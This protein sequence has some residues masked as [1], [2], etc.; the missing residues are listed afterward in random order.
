M[1]KL[2]LVSILFVLAFK[3]TSQVP[4]SMNGGEPVIVYA[5]P[6]TELCIQ[7]EIE[8]TSQQPGMFYRYAGRY[9]ATN[10]IITEEKTSY[11][12]KSIRVLPRA[13]PDPARTFSYSG[14]GNLSSVHISLS[15]NGILCGVNVPVETPGET[16]KATV[17]PVKEN[18]KP[19]ALLPLGEEYMMAGSEAKLAEGA[20]K[21]IYRIRESRLSLLT[22]DIDKLPSDG[23]SFK[24]MLDGMNTLESKLTE[25]F[26][27]KT[28][29]ESQTQT[30]YLT[31][32]SAVANDVLF[33][34]SAIKGLVTVDDLSGVPYYISIKP[35]ES[36]MNNGEKK[37]NI[38]KNSI[39]YILP[40]STLITIGDGVN[41]LLS[42]QFF[43]PQFGITIPLPGDVLKRSGVRIHIDSQSG[44]LLRVE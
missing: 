8:R 35:A 36:K 18:T 31:P 19:E 2:F 3:A 6:Q 9:L 34:L 13:I 1:K 37:P 16:P 10:K 7:V 28:T 4:F 38:V 40:A 11:R 22:A 43:I 27:G 21:Q 33:R 5:L 39:F 26:T 17:L 42:E 30:L 25:L 24:S 20:A 41:T 29:I 12:L 44:R 23:D 32:T 15:S 14:G